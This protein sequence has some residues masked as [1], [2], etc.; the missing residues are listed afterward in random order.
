MK[1]GRRGQGEQGELAHCERPENGNGDDGDGASVEGK[2][3]APGLQVDG[4]SGVSG[5][6][7]RSMWPIGRG[8]PRPR[9]RAL[10]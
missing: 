5:K 7:G 8:M 3:Y 10:G 1:V 9:P 2:G 4:E 6:V